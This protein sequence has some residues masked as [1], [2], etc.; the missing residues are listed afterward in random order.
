MNKHVLPVCLGY[1]TFDSWLQ[2]KREILKNRHL[3]E[4]RRAGV[5][6]E[7]EALKVAERHAEHTSNMLKNKIEIISENLTAS[8]TEADM[9]ATKVSEFATQLANPN[10]TPFE[11][12]RIKPRMEY[13][14]ELYQKAANNTKQHTKELNDLSTTTDPNIIRSDFSETFRNLVDTFKDFLSTISPE[15]LVILFNLFGYLLIIFILTNITLLLI[16]N[17]IIEYFQLERKYPEIEKYIKYKVVLRKYLLRVYI[18]YFYFL[19]LVLIS[20]NTFMFF[21]N[22]LYI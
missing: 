9:S 16:G 17:E 3:E 1:F 19:I 21:Y 8:I 14:Q 10:T 11:A 13:Y 5:L 15:Q 20:L 2:G 22:Y 7:E 12:A 6:K 4:L 18:I